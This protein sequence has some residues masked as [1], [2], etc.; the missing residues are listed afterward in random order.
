MMGS[1][2]VAHVQIFAALFQLRVD[3]VNGVYVAK[4]PLVQN[5]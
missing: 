2:A 5:Q 3:C 4:P 1:S